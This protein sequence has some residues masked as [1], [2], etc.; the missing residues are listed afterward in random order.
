MKYSFVVAGLALLLA[1]SCL[2]AQYSN[3]HT[4]N[5]GEIGIFGDYFRFTQVSPTINFVGLGGRLGINTNPHVALEGEISYDFSRNFTSSSS[6][7]AT[8]SFSRTTLRPLTGLF[9][10]KFQVGTSGPFRAFLTG[11]VGFLDFSTSNKAI[12]TSQFTGAFNNIG[13]PSTHF[14]AYPGGGIEMFGGPI[15]FR[16]DVGDLIYLNNGTYNNLKITAGPAFRF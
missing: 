2:V 3:P 16:I 10:P 11:K 13:G 15:G 4:W 6:N 7:G 9:G 8:T 12:T 14:A 1:P 5:H